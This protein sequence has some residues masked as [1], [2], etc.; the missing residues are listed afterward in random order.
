[1]RKR[2]SGEGTDGVDSLRRRRLLIGI[3]TGLVA[4]TSMGIG[5]AAGQ[6]GDVTVS[7]DN[8]SITAWEVTDVAGGEDV[9]P[10]GESNPTLT[11]TIGTRYVFE[12][13][14]WSFHA[15]AF[16]DANDDPLLTQDGTGWF[17]DDTAVDWVDE[18]ETLA[19]TLTEELANELDD[20]V[21]TVH[22]SMNGP[23]VT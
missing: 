2:S 8:V 4:A 16:R 20:Y 19:F 17:E 18:G 3:G 23:V 9:A 6:S 10:T 7:M 11:L 12:N 13:G 22:T 15:L 5:Q 1:M 21:C 14:G